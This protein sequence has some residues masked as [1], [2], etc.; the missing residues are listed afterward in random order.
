LK[1]IDHSQRLAP[2]PMPLTV[3]ILY[4]AIRKITLFVLAVTSATESFG[5]ITIMKTEA[6]MA[7]ITQKLSALSL[8]AYRRC[9]SRFDLDA[10]SDRALRDIGFRLDRQDLNSVKP[11]WLA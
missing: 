6:V 10:L 8:L 9:H 2:K 7:T 1:N 11:F 5:T 3:V 4:V